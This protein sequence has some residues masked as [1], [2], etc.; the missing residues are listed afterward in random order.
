VIFTVKDG[1]VVRVDPYMDRDEALE[2]TG[3]SELAMSQE[4][5]EVVR[6]WVKAINEGDSATLVAL[7]DPDVDYLP[8]LASIGG[9]AS[10][11]RGHDGLRQYLRDLGS[12][13]L[14]SRRDPRSPRPGRPRADGGAAGGEGAV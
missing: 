8:Y 6:Q 5:V 2:A 9:D 14:V 7:A 3:L 11:Y 12:M 4:N 10:A 1:S 13:G